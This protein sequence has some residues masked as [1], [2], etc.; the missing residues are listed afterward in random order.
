MK[1]VELKQ[2]TVKELLEQMFEIKKEQMN[3]R[4]QKTSGERVN[5]ARIKMLRRLN[6][7][8]KT[9]LTQIKL[10]GDNNA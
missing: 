6:A 1:Y 2:K 5:P 4:F 9:V 3:L 7:R 8:I 10:K